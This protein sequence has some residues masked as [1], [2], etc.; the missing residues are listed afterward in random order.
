MKTS[1]I[2]TRNELSSGTPSRTSSVT[3][4]KPRG[5]ER[6]VISVW[7]HIESAES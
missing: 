4:W 1:A 6:S 7:I 5:R 2:P 3:R